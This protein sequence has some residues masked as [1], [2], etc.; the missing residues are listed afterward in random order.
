MGKAGI[1]FYGALGDFEFDADGVVSS[2]SGSP[3]ATYV[4]S[5][6]NELSNRGYE[7]WPIEKMLK[8]EAYENQ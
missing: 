6:V 5:I 1:S 7:V 3:V 4:W 8:I 2:K